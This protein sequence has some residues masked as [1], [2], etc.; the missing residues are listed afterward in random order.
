MRKLILSMQVSLDGYAEGP[1]GDMSW[2]Q[3]DDDEQWNDLFKMLKDN[4]DLF[5][6]GAGM[7]P[8]YRDYWKKALASP[9]DFSDHELEYA[10][11]A[12]KTQ[13]I[14]FS[15]TLKNAGWENTIINNGDIAAEVKKIK[16]QPGKIYR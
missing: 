1:N 8:E 3:P 15:K 4:V 16:E 13:H 12:G 7:W 10:K 14:V 6:L 9:A 5:L 2:M 11:L